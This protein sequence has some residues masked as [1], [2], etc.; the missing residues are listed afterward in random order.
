MLYKE[1]LPSLDWE[2][3]QL[4]KSAEI[5]DELLDQFLQVCVDGF[6]FESDDWMNDNREKLATSTIL[7][8]LL[9]DKG[10]L[11]GISFY[12]APAVTLSDSHILWEDGIC[13]VKA[14]QHQGYSQQAII[15]AFNFFPERQFNWL[16]CRTQNPA[17]M[18]RY[19]RFGNLF[20]FDQLY[21]S[22]DGQPIMEFLLE[23][24]A[25]VQTTYQ[26]GKLNT[27]NG[28]CNQLYPQGRLGD[29]WVNLDKAAHFER[30]LQDWEFQR[31]RGDAVILVSSLVP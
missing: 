3:Q 28:V 8:K 6:G 22:V 9:D 13:L 16:G 26:R 1:P 2:F 23:H 25:E 19:A 4:D 27:V 24:I 5:S 20:P 15:K 30:Q 12:S 18:M 17:M 31:D 14:A 21:D 7:G 10:Q 29:Y 11:Y